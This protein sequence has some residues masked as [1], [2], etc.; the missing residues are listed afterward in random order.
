MPSEARLLRTHQP[1]PWGTM[2]SARRSKRIRCRRK[3]CSRDRRWT[4]NIDGPPWAAGRTHV[5]S[6]FA[7]R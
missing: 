6:G 7:V 3:S 2:R 1:R 4:R 5:D